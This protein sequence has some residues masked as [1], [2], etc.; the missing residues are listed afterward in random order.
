M[1]QPGTLFL[2]RGNIALYVAFINTIRIVWR[3]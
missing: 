2:A 1:R 3:D